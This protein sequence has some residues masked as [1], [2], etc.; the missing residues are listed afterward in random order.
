MELETLKKEYIKYEKQYKLPSF[1]ELNE[2]FEIE[3][4]DRESECFLRA[5][6]KVMMDKIVNSITFFDM[7]LNPTQSP[8]IYLP[9][10]K[11]MTPQDKDK[12]EKIYEFFGRVSLD[13]MPL[14]LDYSEKAEAEMI[15]RVFREFQLIRVEFKELLIKIGKPVFTNNKKERSYYG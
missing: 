6:R 14:E 3:K 13:C 8:R 5:V 10:I 1:R 15:K 7:L 11:S 12:I 4:I 2:V 9:F